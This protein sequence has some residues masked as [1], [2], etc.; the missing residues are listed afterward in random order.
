MDNAITEDDLDRLEALTA[1][2]TPEPWESFIEEREPIGRSSFIQLGADGYSPPDMYVYHDAKTAPAADLDFI[3]AARKYMPRLIREV[4]HSGRAR[5]PKALVTFP[6]AG[7]RRG[8]C[9]QTLAS[10]RGWVAPGIWLA[11]IRGLI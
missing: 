10:P 2:A 5:A 8:S 4:R 11:Q 7:P 3:A 9:P 6:H 1:A